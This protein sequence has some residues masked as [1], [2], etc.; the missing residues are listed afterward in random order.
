MI[1]LVTQNKKRFLL[2]WSICCFDLNTILNIACFV[3]PF[4]PRKYRQGMLTHQTP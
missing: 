4:S 1:P 2:I 3:F